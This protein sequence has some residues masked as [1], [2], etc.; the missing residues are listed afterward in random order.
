MNFIDKFARKS[1]EI[2][3]YL[4]IY[5]CFKLESIIGNSKKKEIKLSENDIIDTLTYGLQAIYGEMFKTIIILL[6]ALYLDILLP[7]FVVMLSFSIIRTIAGGKHLHSSTK[8]L[9][10]TSVLILVTGH[11]V[12]LVTSEFNW[13]DKVLTYIIYG[14]VLE[15]LSTTIGFEKILDKFDKKE[16]TKLN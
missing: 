5:D 12:N 10:F 1:A 11:H 3:V 6:V 9:V 15:L 7:V 16:L 14:I 2:I 8:C 13:L 4:H